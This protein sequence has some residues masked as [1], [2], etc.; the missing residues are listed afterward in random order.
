MT[1]NDKIIAQ[2]EKQMIQMKPGGK[3]MFDFIIWIVMVIIGAMLLVTPADK[4]AQQFPKMPSIMAAKVIGG[5][6]LVVGI[7]IIVVQI[8]TWMGKM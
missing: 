8:L 2:N 5:I 1:R 7:V 3:E 4:L 6:V